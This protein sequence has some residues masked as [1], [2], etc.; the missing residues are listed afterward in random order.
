MK[1]IIFILAAL[2]TMAF[3]NDQSNPSQKNSNAT[4]Q[5]QQ[6]RQQ[7]AIQEGIDFADKTKKEVVNKEEF[8]DGEAYAKEMC[9]QYPIQCNI[10]NKYL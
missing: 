4:G 10:K 2:S 8:K 6:S 7:K 9:K 3:A 1:K 5:D